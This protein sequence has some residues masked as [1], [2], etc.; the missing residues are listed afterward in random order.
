MFEEQLLLLQGSSGHS[1]HFHAQFPFSYMYLDLRLF[2]YFIDL[3]R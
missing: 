1:V 3:H 2:N